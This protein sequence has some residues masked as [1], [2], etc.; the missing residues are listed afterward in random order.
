[1]NA[2]GLV[3]KNAPTACKGILLAVGMSAPLIFGIATGLSALAPFASFGAMV[4]IQITPRHGVRA[5]IAGVL[6]GCLLIMLAA[7]ISEIL[8]RNVL[9]ALMFLFLL[10]WLSALPKEELAYLSFVIKCTTVAVLISFFDLSPSLP[11]GIYFLCGAIWGIFLSMANMAFE[12]ENQESPIKQLREL[13]HGAT[14]NRYYCIA[15]PVTVIGS[16]L[17]ASIFNFRDPA[18]VG[19]TVIFVARAETS[20]ELKRIFERAGGTLAGTIIAFVVVSQ[21]SQPL[22]LALIV[23]FFAFFVPFF[24]NHYALFSMTATCLILLF[25]DIIMSSQGGDISILYWR[26]FDTAFGCVCVLAS[27]TILKMIYRRKQAARP[28]PAKGE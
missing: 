18:W 7:S 14:N 21:I 19:L 1:M 28:L 13:L 2:D 23:A 26:F 6:T 20:E 24:L 3:K 16:T 25:I 12:S 8:T 27:N 9:L 15:V 10:S 22:Q 5:R 11:M 4:S 17:I